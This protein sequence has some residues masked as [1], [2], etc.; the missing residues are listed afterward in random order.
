MSLDVPADATAEEAA[1]IA[2]AVS[3]YL[4]DEAADA[5]ATDGQS[6]DR[7]A[8][9]GRVA[10]LQGRSVRVSDSAPA[11]PWTAAGRSRRL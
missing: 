5:G 1:A 3:A 9:A 6:R 10:A 8:F 4:A 7:W 11:D 2:A